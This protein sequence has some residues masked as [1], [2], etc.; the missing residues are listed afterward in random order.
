MIPDTL[1]SILIFASDSPFVHTAPT[2]SDA[3]RTSF[4]ESNHYA[5]EVGYTGL[6]NASDCFRARVNRRI[7]CII[8]REALFDMQTALFFEVTTFQHSYEEL[9]HTIALARRYDEE[10]IRVNRGGK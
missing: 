10:H 5:V 8:T 3:L 1:H 4:L 7:R 2:E 6:L 9:F